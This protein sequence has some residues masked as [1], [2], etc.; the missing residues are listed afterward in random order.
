MESK[1]GLVFS[2][3][4][5]PQSASPGA[6]PLL[7]VVPRNVERQGHRH[8]EQQMRGVRVSYIGFVIPR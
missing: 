2:L 6:K 7:P 8:E 5:W 4:D 1:L 3:I